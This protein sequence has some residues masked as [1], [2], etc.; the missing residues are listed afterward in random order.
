MHQRRKTGLR[1]DDGRGVPTGTGRY[2]ERE[3]V[4]SALL[5]ATTA[6]YEID[7][8]QVVIQCVCRSIVNASPHIR[9]AWAWFGDLDATLIKPQIFAGPAASYAEALQIPRNEVTLR[10]PAYRALLDEQADYLAI[11][12]TSGFAPWRAA[13][14]TLGFQV[15]V[16][17][18]LR[19]RES[20]RRGILI[21]Y[22]DDID[23]FETVGI[24]P[25]R[26][27]ARVAETAL[28]QA[29]VSRQLREQAEI[30]PLT[31]LH[32]RRYMD[33]ELVRLR[34]LADRQKAP[35]VL[36]IIDIDHFKFV[37]DHYGHN[38]GDAVL[39]RL[40]DILR[41][42]LRRE[43][44]SARWGGDEFLCALPGTELAEA[45]TVERRIRARVEAD[46]LVVMDRTLSWRVSIGIASF[47]DGSEP[48]EAVLKRAD[49][50]LYA[51]KAQR[52]EEAV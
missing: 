27:L 19:V 36:M 48:V 29:T 35:S 42:E 2:T 24:E 4:L 34:A 50:E 31:G 20:R 7:D 38:A 23:Y 44:S 22:A 13:S 18:P 25:F 6:L 49:D 10:G 5:N 47:G 9:L 46:R 45:A 28:S 41:Q 3:L 14:V 15:A 37:N 32:N 12:R 16:A 39:G 8:P 1:R 43:D 21:F 11:S 33:R 17:F 40:A 26:A 30:D 52:V 51:A